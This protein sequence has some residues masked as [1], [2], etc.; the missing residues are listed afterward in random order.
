MAKPKTPSAKRT[1]KKPSAPALPAYVRPEDVYP[2]RRKPQPHR[3]KK[4]IGP[5]SAPAITATAC[6]EFLAS[7]PP[8]EFGCF[9][10][11]EIAAP[12]DRGIGSQEE[13]H[14]VKK[15]DATPIEE[16]EEVAAE[17]TATEEER[18]RA[19]EAQIA[20]ENA[21]AAEEPAPAEAPSA[22]AE[23]PEEVSQ[24]VAD[25]A[26]AMREDEADELELDYLA[27]DIRDFLLGHLRTRPKP[28]AQMS[29]VEQSEVAEAAGMAARNLVRSVVREV[30]QFD[31]DRVVVTL[32]DVKIAAGNKGIEAKISCP[33]SHEAREALGENVGAMVVLLMVDSD[34]FM[35][36]RRAPKIDKDQ[37]DLPLGGDTKDTP[38]A[39]GL[40]PPDP[41]L[42]EAAIDVV[43][44]GEPSTS[45][46]QR[47]MS[48]SYLL[49][50]QVM[51]ALE[52][53]QIVSKP[54]RDGKREVLSF[55][56]P[57]EPEATDEVDEEELRGEPGDTP[58]ESH[59][60]AEEPAEV[61]D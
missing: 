31:F 37:P 19:A 46:V 39:G 38:A 20:E 48:I 23:E 22:E 61:E 55:A 40:E 18:I 4:Q 17:E 50:A 5:T 44:N 57:A 6:N 58:E 1:R 47:T 11:P 56:D 2:G 16:A 43:R 30:T 51:S 25:Y 34:E 59:E 42:V 54:D 13:N 45:Y 27:D 28:W 29:E 12:A 3:L 49:A 60:L 8:L 41:Q 7:L 10:H 53:A 32:G 52:E 9:D 35:A 21:A 36:E 26:G 14:M 33:N 24:V 15:E